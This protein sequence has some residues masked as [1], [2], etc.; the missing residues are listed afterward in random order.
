[1]KPSATVRT[2]QRT[3]HP[4]EDRL[5]CARM[6][7]H[8]PRRLARDELR[9]W[10]PGDAFEEVDVVSASPWPADGHRT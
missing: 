6:R 4:V 2:A 7:L 8:L 10:L 1:M 3:V 9:A 5:R